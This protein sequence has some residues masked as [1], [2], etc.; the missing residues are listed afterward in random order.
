[1]CYAVTYFKTHWTQVASNHYWVVNL[2]PSSKHGCSNSLLQE[3]VYVY[4]QLFCDCSIIHII[5][6]ITTASGT[7]LVV[8]PVT[9]FLE[10]F[11][12]QIEAL[13]S[14]TTIKMW[15]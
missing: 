11:I 9:P 7:L 2:S 13:T 5:M 8:N 3:P 12:Y 10:Y 1:M 14:C 6:E 4:V 15:I